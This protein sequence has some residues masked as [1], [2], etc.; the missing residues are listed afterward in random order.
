MPLYEV[1]IEFENST[2][3]RPR[4]VEAMNPEAAALRATIGNFGK[5]WGLFIPVGSGRYRVARSKRD[6]SNTY[7]RVRQIAS[8]SSRSFTDSESRS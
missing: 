7:V 1:I 6:Q 8:E 3:S 5:G 4:Q 2:T